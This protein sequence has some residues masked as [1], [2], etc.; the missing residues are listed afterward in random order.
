MLT[1]MISLPTLNFRALKTW[2]ISF[3]AHAIFFI[4]FL[5]VNL[6]RHTAQTDVVE[7]NVYSP[8]T[9]HDALKETFIPNIPKPVTAE[10]TIRDPRK[11]QDNS[12][13][14]TG[15]KGAQ[16]GT[17]G[18]STAAFGNG[19]ADLHIKTG[20]SGEGYG[21]GSGGQGGKVEDNVYHVGVEIMPEPY[22]GIGSIVSKMKLPDGRQVSGNEYILC[23]IDENGVVRRTQV[24]KGIAADV[25]AAVTQAVKRTRF[26]PGKDKG[27][28]IK[29]QMVLNIPVG[30]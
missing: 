8:E 1:P 16:A 26:K 28:P 21:M 4:L 30:D 24:T 7:V 25:D 18:G 5:Y 11:T 29:V 10:P 2:L 6:N 9:K 14:A 27:Q 12:Q 23:F 15:A 17:P 3:S 13:K 19:D 22:G 20:G